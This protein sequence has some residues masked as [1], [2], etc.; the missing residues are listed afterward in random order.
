MHF[1]MKVIYKLFQFEKYFLLGPN[2]GK[3]STVIIAQRR[4]SV[5]EERLPSLKN[6]SDKRALV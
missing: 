2:Y 6:V 5:W 1:N 3:Y 4:V